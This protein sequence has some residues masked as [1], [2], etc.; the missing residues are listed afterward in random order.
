MYCFLDW[1]SV[2]SISYKLN[3][4]KHILKSFLYFATL[5][6]VYFTPTIN[7]NINIY[8]HFFYLWL[9]R[10]KHFYVMCFT[11]DTFLSVLYIS[12]VF[13]IIQFTVCFYIRKSLQGTY[14]K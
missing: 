3:H 12:S 13:Y 8:M 11:F 9:W 1:N 4:K 2:A 6:R 14:E 7:I 5:S 10:G